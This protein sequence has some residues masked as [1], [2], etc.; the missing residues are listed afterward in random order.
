MR[1]VGQA[2][3]QLAHDPMDES[4]RNELFPTRIELAKQFMN[5]PSPPL[6]HG[7]SQF[8]PRCQ[9]GFEEWGGFVVISGRRASHDA[10]TA[11]LTLRLRPEHV[12]V[13]LRG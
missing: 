6:C 8:G 12:G 4:A 2:P 11:I 3:D 5:P 1:R 9:P 7:L 10:R 13:T